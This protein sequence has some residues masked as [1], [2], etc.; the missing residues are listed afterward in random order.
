MEVNPKKEIR[1]SISR[2]RIVLNLFFLL[3]LAFSILPSL[4]ED[5]SHFSTNENINAISFTGSVRGGKKKK[6]REEKKIFFKR[7]KVERNF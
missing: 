3:F 2:D 7:K 1:L 4:P 5:A 6:R